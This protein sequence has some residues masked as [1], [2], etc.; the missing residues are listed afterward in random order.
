MADIKYKIK[1]VVER[2]EDGDIRNSYVVLGCMDTKS[3]QE[4]FHWLRGNTIDSLERIRDFW[5]Y[6]KNNEREE[7]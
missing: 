2:V 5:E 4:Y 6:G 3:A 7:K 1:L